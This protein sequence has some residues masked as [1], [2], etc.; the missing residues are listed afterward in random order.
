M[1]GQIR[2]DTIQ[3]IQDLD[4]PYKRLKAARIAAGYVTA[5]QFADTHHLPEQ[6]YGSH[7]R[8]PTTEGGKGRGIPHDR[9]IEYAKLLATR[10][11]EVTADWIL[12]GA[13]HP[14]AA[15]W[16]LVHD[17]D[18]LP[19]M[20]DAARAIAP[21]ASPTEARLD[22]ELYADVV[23][24]ADRYLRNTRRQLQQPAFTRLCLALYDVYRARSRDEKGRLPD[25][26]E[27]E[28][29]IRLASNAP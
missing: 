21:A 11:P 24:A 12:H 6:T 25:V 13:G 1:R 14:P 5:R 2:P 10:L 23:L 3:E 19:S 8:K 17:P 22:P 7:E 29:L 28:N 20:L 16:Q 26:S 9:A 27:Y 15:V 18:S 4:R